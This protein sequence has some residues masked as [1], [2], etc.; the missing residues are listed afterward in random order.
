MS[1]HFQEEFL[2]ILMALSSNKSFLEKNMCKICFSLDVH[3]H[4]GWTLIRN[5][6]SSI[7]L[8][9]HKAASKRLLGATEPEP[10]IR[11]RII[12]MQLRNTGYFISFN[13][14][15]AALGKRVK[16]FFYHKLL[17]LFVK[18]RVR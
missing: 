12:R 3:L 15:R 18:Q 8:V 16:L 14:I 17:C 4:A 5:C 7:S 13:Q 6:R 1:F 10:Q 2:N 11:S 9:E